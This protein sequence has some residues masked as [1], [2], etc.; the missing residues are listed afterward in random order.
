MRSIFADRAANVLALLLGGGL[1]SLTAVSLVQ[2]AFYWPVLITFL[3]VLVAG[4]F[5]ALREDVRTRGPHVAILPVSYGLSVIVFH[6][7]VS[8]GIFQQLFIIAATGGFLLLM[9]RATE[10]AFPTWTWLFT[11]LT[12]FLS[13]ASL[14]GLTFHLRFPLWATGI[15]IGLMTALLTYHVVGRAFSDLSRRV[16]WS[17]L[18]SLLVVELLF[19]L[20]LFPLAYA[21]V[22]GI[23]FVAFYLLLHLLQRE[24]YDRLSRPVV[25]EYLGVAASIIAVILLTAEWRV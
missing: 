8:R 15:G 22:G 9:A 1:E 17:A 3:G 23:L 18:L 11:S 21:A 5:V 24:T 20:S 13:A 4:T 7:F 12:F 2:R 10:W 25:L 16:F 19:V 14:Y 6:A